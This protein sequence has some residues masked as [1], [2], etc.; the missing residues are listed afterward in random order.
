M[1]VRVWLPARE[2]RS[3]LEVGLMPQAPQIVLCIVTGVQSPMSGRAELSTDDVR[4]SLH[5]VV[6]YTPL[7]AG[8]SDVGPTVPA[9][10]SPLM[11]A[12]IVAG[13][14]GSDSADASCA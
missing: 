11:M 5:R 7:M 10:K 8:V 6:R 1:S 3:K 13:T 9:S 12:S 4:S 2:I 14:K